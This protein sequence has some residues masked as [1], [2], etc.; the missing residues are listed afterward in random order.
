MVA[1]LVSVSGAGIATFKHRYEKAHD[2]SVIGNGIPTVV[3]IHDP[4]CP[5]C[6]KLRENATTALRRVDH[7]IQYRIADITTRPGRLLQ[8]V[9]QVPHVTLLLFDG[10]GELK[11]VIS[12]VSGVESLERAFNS[13][14]NPRARRGQPARNSGAGQRHGESS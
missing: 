7:D 1:I 8:R 11:R 5:K 2:L 14:V 13:H 4:G 6:R 12:G 3:Q 9:H 10:G